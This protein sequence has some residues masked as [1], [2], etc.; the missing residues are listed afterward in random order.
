[1]FLPSK[2]SSS[3]SHFPFSLCSPTFFFSKKIAPPPVQPLAARINPWGLF[4]TAKPWLQ[5][6]PLPTKTLL[7][8]WN[9][10]VDCTL[11]TRRW[12]RHFF[13]MILTFLCPYT[14]TIPRQTR[15][16]CKQ[17]FPKLLA[18]AVEI[19]Y[20]SIKAAK[21]HIRTITP[22]ILRHKI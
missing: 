10:L 20:A 16:S 1:M 18:Q 21:E 11:S 6:K 2:I 19:D 9:T 5:P 13:G 15:V 22:Q 17:I 3:P 7:P 14:S 12:M 8:T 4:Q